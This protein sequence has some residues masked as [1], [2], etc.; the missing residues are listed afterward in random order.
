MRIRGPIHM[1]ELDNKVI[2]IKVNKKIEFFYF[3]NSQMN[4]FKKYLYQDNWIEIEYQ[5]KK[6]S[7]GRFECFPVS[8]IYKIEAIGRRDH[9]VY[10]DK[11]SITSSLYDFLDKLNNTMFLDLEMTMPGY[12]FKGKGQFRTEVI[13]AGIIILDKEGKELYKYS[14]YI[15]PKLQSKLSNR[16]L[17]FLHLS[18][19]EFE[20]TSI[21]YDEFYEAFNEMLDKYNP[22]IIVYG[23]N[24]SIVLNDSY[25][26][27]DKP[28]LKEKTRFINILQLMKSYY[29]LKNEPGLFKLYNVFYDID[30][31][32][33]HDALDDCITT[34][35][36]FEAFKDDLKNKNKISTI[37]TIFN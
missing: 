4:L 12:Q 32:Q 19:E 25:E 27:N 5:N 35:K 34:Y 31:N 28:S 8:F 22:A 15:K 18:E 20:S 10:Y 23:K 3:Q 26:I 16:A 37:R 14:K 11:L 30:E 7:R 21:E 1:I 17:D 36:V 13:Q 6:I 33:V 29:E 9:I 24:D 2:G